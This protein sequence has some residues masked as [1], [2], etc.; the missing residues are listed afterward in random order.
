EGARFTSTQSRGRP[1]PSGPEPASR[2]DLTEV[3]ARHR[4]FAVSCG[5]YRSAPRAARWRPTWPIRRRRRAPE[6][7]STTRQQ[8][9]TV[10]SDARTV[11]VV[12]LPAD[13]RRLRPH[14]E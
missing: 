8:L 11:A 3:I 10:T 12:E 13:E 1:K 2:G 9:R 4:R 7:R 14:E 5:R 6:L